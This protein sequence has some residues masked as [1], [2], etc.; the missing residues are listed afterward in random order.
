M[1]LYSTTNTTY[2]DHERLNIGAYYLPEYAR[3][4]Q[5]VKEVAECGIDFLLNVNYDTDMLDLLEKYGIGAIV[6]GYILSWLDTLRWKQGIKIEER[7]TMDKYEDAARSFRDHPAI[8][9]MDVGDEPAAV[10]FPY[11]GKIVNKVNKL[12]PK[13]FAYLN[14]YPNYA[15]VAKN[16]T[17]VVLSQLGAR[18]YEEYIQLYCENIPTDYICFDFYLYEHFVTRYYENL[19]VVADAAR[20]T[21]RHMWIVLQVNSYKP[22]VWMSE[23]NLRFQAYSSMAFGADTIMWACYG[24]GWWTNQ[25][26]DKEGNKTQQYEKLKKVNAEIRTIADEYMK[27]RRV[28]THFVG[29]SGHPDMESVGKAAIESLNTGV[30]FDLKANNGAPLLVGQMVS[31]TEDGSHAVF[32]CAADDHHEENPKEYHV[33]FRAEDKKITALGGKGRIPVTKTEDG[34][35]SVPIKS[36][37]GILIVAR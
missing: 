24:Q 34:C 15:Q 32:V 23:N 37:E 21:G 28:D 25:V 13:Q 33:V 26:L 7:N 11:F 19:R 20:N 5:H 36:N 35:Y 6:N 27:Y 14:L 22:E 30:F 8:W 9:G 18:T 1:S 17:D 3:S 29:F 16:G 2:F 31:K 12:F 4:E 10:D